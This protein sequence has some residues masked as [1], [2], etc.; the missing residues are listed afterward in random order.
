M[1]RIAVAL[2]VAALSGGAIAQ[3]PAYR[4]GFDPGALKGPAT[5]V[6]NEVLVL[7]TPHLNSLPK[8]FRPEDLE[9]LLDR[10][11]AWRPEVIA[12]EALSGAQ[13]DHLRRHPTRYA[14]SV[15]SYCW[16]VEPA[17]IAT[18]LDV[19]TAIAE[20]ERMLATWPAAPSSAQRRRL[21]AVFLAAGD[22]AS[23]LVQWLRLPAGERRVGDGVD[24]RLATR[25]EVLRASRNEN[26][27][28]AAPLAARL[29]LERVHAT[30]DHTADS[31]TADEKGYAAAMTRIWDNPAVARRRA[32]EDQLNAGLG[33]GAGTLALYRAYNAPGLA[34]LVYDSDFGAAHRD[35]SAG[36]HGRRY[37]GYWETRNLRMAANIRDVLA[38]GPGRRTLT[39][40]G[41]SHK[42]Y[43]E[44]YL[45]T[46]HDVTLVDAA[47]VLR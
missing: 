1:I 4:P 34:R 20:A 13:C 16:D 26:F 27:L 44:A 46:M 12:I 21:A 8:T 47:A 36:Q 43:L 28:L 11:A 14:G 29:G 38:T 10:L 41:V 30:D 9:L 32:M 15:E 39:L 19:P 2:A 5:L 25:L 31:P 23:A 33:S 6:P 3:Q 24:D 37:L 35:R 22:Q 45:H 42:G 17:R 40:V 18:G 7:G